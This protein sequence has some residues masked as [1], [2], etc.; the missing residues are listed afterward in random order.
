MDG[1]EA[2]AAHDVADAGAEAGRERAATDLYEHPIETVETGRAELMADLPPDRAATIEGQR[3]L[4]ALH[5]ERDRAGGH[6]LAEPQHRR[7][8]RWIA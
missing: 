3:V 1:V 8:T 7:V 5:R 4:R 2:D 6:R